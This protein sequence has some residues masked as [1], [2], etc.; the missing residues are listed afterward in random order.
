MSEQSELVQACL[1]LG[2]R[3]RWL[4]L[5]LE[6][7]IHHTKHLQNCLSL[8][9]RSA[10]SKGGTWWQSKGVQVKLHVCLAMSAGWT[11]MSLRGQDA[12]AAIYLPLAEY[13]V[14][15]KQ[16]RS[17]VTTAVSTEHGTVPLNR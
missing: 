12:V 14:G 13:H 7:T 10:P 8:G 11:G 9:W 4:G 5:F 1:A 6:N 3:E 2:K 17:L 16:T 15:I